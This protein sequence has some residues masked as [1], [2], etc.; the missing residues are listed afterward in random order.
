MAKDVAAN[1]QQPPIQ[2]PTI[3]GIKKLSPQDIILMSWLAS[4]LKTILEWYVKIDPYTV[5]D[6]FS[7][8]DNYNYS[9]IVDREQM[10]RIASIIV[11]FKDPLPRLPWNT[12]LGYR[13]IKLS[14]PKHNAATLSHEIMPKNNNNFYPFRHSGK[15][16]G[17]IMFAFQICGTR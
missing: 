8:E 15:I 16:F 4:S 14:L 9:I 13:L 3:D 17:Y 2:A 11:T 5:P 1:V 6:P 10:N 12:I 7:D